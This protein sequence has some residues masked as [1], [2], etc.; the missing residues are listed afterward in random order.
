MCGILQAPARN[1]V[2]YKTG[3]GQP[4]NSS[5]HGPPRQILPDRLPLSVPDRS[6]HG[7]LAPGHAVAV[8]GLQILPEQARLAAAGEG[9][10][11]EGEDA[12]DRLGRVVEELDPQ[13][14]D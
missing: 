10:V 13:V 6:Q 4:R 14:A 12:R 5:C 1:S 3:P 11:V 2:P 8:R 9:V 7:E